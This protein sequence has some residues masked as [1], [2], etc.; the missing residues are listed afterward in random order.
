[1]G[2]LIVVLLATRAMPK[3][4]VPDKGTGSSLGETGKLE[5][6]HRPLEVSQPRSRA[7]RP[8]LLDKQ[9]GFLPQKTGVCFSP[10]S[11]QCPRGAGLPRTIFLI[12]TIPWTWNASP[13]GLQSRAI[14]GIPWAAAAE[15][16]AP[17]RPREGVKT[18][19]AEEEEQVVVTNKD[20]ARQAPSLE[21]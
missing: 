3:I 2:L 16:A 21:M 19:R 8:K 7:P 11:V 4:R 6:R 12:V 9:I 17:V 13:P 10:L 20:G 5:P 15:A 1:M 18:V 14:K